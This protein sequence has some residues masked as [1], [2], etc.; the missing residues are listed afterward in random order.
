MLHPRASVFFPCKLSKLQLSL[1]HVASRMPQSFFYAEIRWGPDQEGAKE[2]PW[3]KWCI[4]K[5]KSTC[6]LALLSLHVN[7]P[8]HCWFISRKNTHTHKISIHKL[9]ERPDRAV[10]FY[11]TH[12]KRG[13]CWATVE[14]VAAMQKQHLHE[15]DQTISVM[16]DLQVGLRQA[17]YR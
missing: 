8:L 16:A 9:N 11:E 13:R 7:L 14:I 1:K 17:S 2:V 10:Q 6:L 12:Y 5:M 3:I 4:P 15:Q